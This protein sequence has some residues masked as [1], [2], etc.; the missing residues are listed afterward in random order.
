MVVPYGSGAGRIGGWDGCGGV[1]RGARGFKPRA[2]VR[3][4]PSDRGSK[5]S[6]GR[7]LGTRF[8]GFLSVLASLRL[9]TR[10]EFDPR[11]CWPRFHH[12][13]DATRS[14]DGRHMR[15]SPTANVPRIARPGDLLFPRVS[16]HLSA[17]RHL[18]QNH[19]HASAVAVLCG[20]GRADFFCWFCTCVS[21]FAGLP[22][23]WVVAG[24]GGDWRAPM[25]FSREKL[26]SA[27]RVQENEKLVVTFRAPFAMRGVYALAVFL[28]RRP[29][30]VVGRVSRSWAAD[31]VVS[32]GNSV[33]RSVGFLNGFCPQD[34]ERRFPGSPPAGSAPTGSR[35]GAF[36]S[37]QVT[38][39]LN[40][41]GPLFRC[42][43]AHWLHEDSSDNSSVSPLRSVV[44]GLLPAAV[45]EFDCLPA[46]W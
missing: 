38:R 22:G 46:G 11:V 26:R 6:P 37:P 3:T 2:A 21:F 25:P 12:V 24:G 29:D 20:I 18:S 10:I 35:R 41:R 19:R 4:R 14:P 43:L 42:S 13:A 16:A 9:M 32:N 36:C 27:W 15:A 1:W 23:S 44:R 30:V 8:A 45:V 39:R 17:H 5:V 28:S 34:I 33:N 31:G 7:G 40:P